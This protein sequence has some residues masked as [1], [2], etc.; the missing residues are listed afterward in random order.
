MTTLALTCPEWTAELP[1]PLHGEVPVH[2]LPARPDRADLDPLLTP[3]DGSPTPTRVVVAGT[4]ADLAAVVL[5]LL[6]TERLAEV[7][8][9]YLPADR[10]SAVAATWGLPTAPASAATLAR[11]GEPDLVP[12]VR[13]DVGGV[14]L[15]RGEL[16][17]LRGVVYC[18]DQLVLR[19]QAN[20]LV[21]TPVAPTGVDV[22]AS[23]VG[24]LGLVGRRTN[25][26]LG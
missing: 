2:A 20:R 19:G 23:R 9:A 11:H 1:A 10:D 13:D 18:D 17:P 24:L 5:R 21:V 22:R 14:L 25:A 15:G 8:V 16:R 12:L 3:A 6:R 4:D 7:A 26:A